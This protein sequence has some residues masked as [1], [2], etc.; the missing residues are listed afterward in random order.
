MN[1]SFQNNFCTFSLYERVLFFLFKIPEKILKID[2]KVFKSSSNVLSRIFMVLITVPSQFLEIV[3]ILQEHCRFLVNFS[4]R[5]IL[6][7]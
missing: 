1:R 4:L 3:R 5:I 2:L 7:G 6:T